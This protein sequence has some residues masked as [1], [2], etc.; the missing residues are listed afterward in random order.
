MLQFNHYFANLCYYYLDK[1]VIKKG[2]DGIGRHAFLYHR[3]VE[4][5]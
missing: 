3:C 4:I 2:N 5:W 1:R